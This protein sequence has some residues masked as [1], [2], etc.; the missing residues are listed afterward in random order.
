MMMSNAFAALA[1]ACLLLVSSSTHANAAASPRQEVRSL[2]DSNESGGKALVTVS[3]IADAVDADS[4][5][6]KLLDAT[7]G[8]A[9]AATAEGEVSAASVGWCRCDAPRP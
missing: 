4:S 5:A 6:P 7:P 9:L 2:A 3:S 1:A 8:A